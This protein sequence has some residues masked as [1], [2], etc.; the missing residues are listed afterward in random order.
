MNTLL[1]IIALIPNVLPEWSVCVVFYGIINHCIVDNCESNNI[2]EDKQ[3]GFRLKRSCEDHIYTLTSIIRNRLLHK[4]S[5]YLCSIDIQKAFDW[6]DGDILFYILLKYNING[7][8]YK[9]IKV[10]YIH[11]VACVKINDNVTDSFSISSH[12]YYLDCS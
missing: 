2:Y 1:A 5:T 9:C 6:V 11:Q 10:I 7:N 12:Q 4:Q 3:N 8:I